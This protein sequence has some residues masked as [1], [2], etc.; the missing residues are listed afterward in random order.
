MDSSILGWIIPLSGIVGGAIGWVGK[1]Y[2]Y[3][4]EAKRQAGLDADE[5]LKEKKT[6]LEEL[7]SKTSNGEQKT[8]Y[9]SCLDDVNKAL[10]GLSTA[11]IRRTLKDAGLPPEDRLIIEGKNQLQ[12]QQLAQLNKEIADVQ[13]LPSSDSIQDL[14]AIANSYY[15]TGKVE[16]AK[17]IYDIILKLD[18][19]NPIA[20]NNRGVILANLE[21]EN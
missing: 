20:L 18:P 5:T 6:L 7:I 17:N 1:Q 16:D 19:N 12:P 2:Q 21:K 3:R 10:I 15:V 14:L 9:Q 8:K 4:R 11:R 13:R